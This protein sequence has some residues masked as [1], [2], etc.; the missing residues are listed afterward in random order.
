LRDLVEHEA[1]MM[2]ERSAS[3][4]QEDAAP[5]ALEQ[6]HAVALIFVLAGLVK[7]VTGMGLPTV[8]MGLLGLLMT[9]AQA[10]AFLVIPSLITNVWQFLL[11]QHRL[12]LIH[13]TW[14]MLLMIC[15]AT[16][17]AVGLMT[18]PGAERAATWLG[19]ALIAYAGI[20]FA[21]VRLSVPRKYEAWLSPAMG[22]ATGVVSGA[23][24]V[25]VIPAVP[26][27]QALGFDKDDLVQALGL[28]FTTS[29][30]ALAAGLTSHGAFQ[31]TDAGTS[32]VCVA[33]AFVG[34][35]IGQIV[36]ARMDPAT[37]RLLFLGGLLLLGGDLIARS[38]M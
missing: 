23:T 8:A 31:I 16:W 36:R 22:A 26:Y 18:G 1:S 28:S 5:A 34:M 30:L 7:G 10:A 21:K 19:A 37:F 12:V 35:G 15:L 33:P 4:R 13:R 3:G 14:P 29:T 32:A 9:P 20:G 25:F 2:G 24:G 17:A 38:I 27:L 11:G 6:S